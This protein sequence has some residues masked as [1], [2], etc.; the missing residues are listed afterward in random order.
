MLI[1]EVTFTTEAA[2][3]KESRPSRHWSTYSCIL[4]LVKSVIN[5]FCGATSE[6]NN[7]F[8]TFSSASVLRPGTG[9]NLYICIFTLFMRNICVDF[10]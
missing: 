3:I 10:V 9:K 5:L 1:I 2:A 7:Q 6:V 4:L 8:D